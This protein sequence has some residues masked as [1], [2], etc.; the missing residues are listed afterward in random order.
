[1]KVS[2]LRTPNSE[3]RT[4]ILYGIGIGP[5]DPELLTLKAEKLLKQIDVLAVPKSKDEAES[6]ALSVVAHAVDIKEKEI[7]ELTLPMT[8]DK[9]VLVKARKD[10]ALLLTEKLEKGFDIACI[11]LG[12]PLFYSTFSYLM[13]FVTDILPDAEIKIIPG[14]SSIHAAASAALTPLA[15][16]DERIAIIPAA[17][18]EKDLKKIIESFDTVV[19]MKINKVFNNVLT[20]LNELGLKEKTVFVS[21]AGWPDEKIV[22]NMDSLNGKKIDYFSMVIIKK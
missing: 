21:K 14:V 7:I 16:A 22:R 12:D 3:L 6:R 19:L 8:R 4:G 13:P 18:G 17:Y 10:A 9:D 5:G 20:V 15:E 11:T 1:M 2:K